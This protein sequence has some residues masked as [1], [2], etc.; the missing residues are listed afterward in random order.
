MV[1]EAARSRFGLAEPG[2]TEFIHSPPDGRQV[3]CPAIIR[4]FVAI[5]CPEPC[6]SEDVVEDLVRPEPPSVV[7]P[8]NV[9]KKTARAQDPAV[10]GFQ[11]VLDVAHLPA[12]DRARFD[13]LDLGVATLPPA[14]LGPALLEPHASW[15]VRIGQEWVQRYGVAP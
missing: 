2:P 15:M 9:G 4:R 3:A 13:A 8:R 1:V 5:T 12:V 11:T 7:E 10:L 6:L 14:D